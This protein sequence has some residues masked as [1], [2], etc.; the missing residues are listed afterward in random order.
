MAG[1]QTALPILLAAFLLQQEAQSASP[2]VGDTHSQ[3]VK[4]YADTDFL[5]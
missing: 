3:Q 4:G 5:P 2:G 1:W